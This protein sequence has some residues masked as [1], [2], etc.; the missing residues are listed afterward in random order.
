MKPVWYTHTEV[1]APT[2]NNAAGS[3]I[4]L[5]DALLITGFN[6]KAVTSISVASGVATAV[7]S[8]HGYEAGKTILVSGATPTG[9]NG[10]QV[11]ASVVDANTVTFAVSGVADG[12]ATGTIT[13]KRAPLG[14]VKAF[15]GTNTAVYSRPESGA[16]TML[17]RVDDTGAGVA[18]ATSARAVMVETAAGVDS[19]TAAA[20]T[21]AQLSG[22]VWLSKGANST[23]PKA[24]CAFGDGRTLYLFTDNASY[25]LANTGGLHAFGFGD[26]SSW[27]AG[28]VY[29]CMIVGGPGE[30][31][32]YFNI[33]SDTPSTGFGI[34][35]SRLSNQIG[36]A[37]AATFQGR[38]TGGQASGNAQ[39]S[40]GG[41]YP[42][43][44]DNGMPI[45][46][47]VLVR[48]SNS[49]GG[50]PYRGVAR[51]F[52]HPLAQ[53]PSSMHMTQ[54]GDLIGTTDK[55]VFVALSAT[56]Y[57]GGVLFNI[58]SDWGA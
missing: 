3:L 35:L 54:F 38:M 6:T 9:L 40:S 22:G 42:S 20:P 34:Y 15:A 2:L 57:Q 49:G 7:I 10:N 14:W 16:T 11:I 18:S 26:I 24:W 1:G 58:T 56:G 19:Y 55:Y 44:V 25:S 28:D 36:S 30:T 39:A 41:V 45:E 8:G 21:T 53:L 13:A 4:A 5:L 29:S 37:V 50:N 17:L 32:N 12:G 47:T 52:A 31:N 46:R 51:G 43:P 23:T 27:R 33:S 48:E